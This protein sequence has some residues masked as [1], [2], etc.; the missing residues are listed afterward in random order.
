MVRMQSRSYELNPPPD[1]RNRSRNN[2]T[3][4]QAPSLGKYV[5]GGN[6]SCTSLPHRM[7]KI[8]QKNILD[9]PFFLLFDG[10]FVVF[11]GGGSRILDNYKVIISDC[12]SR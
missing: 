7:L 12:L 11:G 10:L 5:F 4:L 1:L 3:L 8:N 6:M 9:F 2:S